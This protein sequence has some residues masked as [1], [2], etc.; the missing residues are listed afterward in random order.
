MQHANPY[1]SFGLRCCSQSTG[2]HS[3]PSNTHLIQKRLRHSIQP[4]KHNFSKWL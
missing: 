2:T 1:I 3:L 4:G